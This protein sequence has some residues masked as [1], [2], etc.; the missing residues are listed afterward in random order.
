MS[1]TFRAEE[2]IAERDALRMNFHHAVAT[3]NA[4]KLVNE[5][6]RNETNIE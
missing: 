5:R 2:S 1:T 3:F 4:E 6:R